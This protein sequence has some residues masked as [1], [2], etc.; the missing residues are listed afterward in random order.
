MQ[1]LCD[2]YKYSLLNS[3][4]LWH[5]IGDVTS[6]KR[7]IF[8]CWGSFVDT[9]SK[10]WKGLDCWQND[11]WVSRETVETTYAVW[12]R[13]KNWFVRQ[14]GSGRRR[15]VRTASNIRLVDELICSQDGQPG[16][17]KSP[18]EIAR[19]IKP[20]RWR[21]AKLATKLGISRSSVVRIAKNDLKLKVFRRHKVQSLTA[22]DKLKGLNACKRLKKRIYDTENDQSHMVL[23]W[24][25]F[26]SGDAF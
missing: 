13:T 15:S 25:D 23:R 4:K 14:R 18:R 7:G 20:R 3:R 2:C 5:V 16:T 6:C 9:N 24:K 11:R 21:A 22:A 17:S 26:Y 19:H 1:N 10:N 12:S 8:D